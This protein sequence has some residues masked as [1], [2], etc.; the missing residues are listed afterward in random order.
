MSAVRVNMTE[1]E[2]F[3]SWKR[4][5]APPIPQVALLLNHL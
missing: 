1:N 4:Q 2:I 5:A 3:R